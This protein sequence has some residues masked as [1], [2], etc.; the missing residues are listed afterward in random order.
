MILSPRN[1]LGTCPIHNFL[2]FL[3]HSGRRIQ[4][5]KLARGPGVARKAKSVCGAPLLAMPS[6][7]GRGLLLTPRKPALGRGQ[8]TVGGSALQVAQTQQSRSAASVLQTR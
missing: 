6:L 3:A 2:A 1:R 5:G 4:L 7:G 8:G